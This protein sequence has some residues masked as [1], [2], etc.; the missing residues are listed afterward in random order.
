[1]NKNN[2]IKFRLTDI[3]KEIIKEKAKENGFTS[4][5]EYCRYVAMNCKL[6]IEV[7]MENNNG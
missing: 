2:D 1:M 5:S 3:E 7:Y 4:V 6:K